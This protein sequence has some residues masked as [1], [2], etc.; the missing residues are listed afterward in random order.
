MIR[1][2][3]CLLVST[4]LFGCS[5]LRPPIVWDGQTERNEERIIECLKD[6]EAFTDIRYM[7]AS[8]FGASVKTRSYFLST[9]GTLHFDD[10]RTGVDR[11]FVRAERDLTPKEDDALSTCAPYPPF[12]DRLR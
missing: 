10:Y 9:W 2:G 12:L 3:V 11:I 6:A 4:G 1:A 5:D 7:S 8:G